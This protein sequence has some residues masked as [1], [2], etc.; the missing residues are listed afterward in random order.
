[1]SSCKMNAEEI[2]RRTK[3]RN[4]EYNQ[5]ICRYLDVF[6]E[7]IQNSMDAIERRAK[8]EKKNGKDNWSGKI[9]PS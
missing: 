6:S 5:I 1:M 7:S 3:K 2:Q 8:L 4:N 9:E